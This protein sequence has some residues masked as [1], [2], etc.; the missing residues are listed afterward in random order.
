MCSPS[1][2]RSNGVYSTVTPKLLSL[3]TGWHD[4]IPSK[5]NESFQTS[6]LLIWIETEAGV[7]FDIPATIFVKGTV[8]TSSIHTV[9][10]EGPWMMYSNCQSK[11]VYC[12][13]TQLSFPPSLRPKTGKWSASASWVNSCLQPHS[14]DRQT[15]VFHLDVNSLQQRKCA[16]PHRETDGVQGDGR[17]EGEDCGGLSWSAGPLRCLSRETVAHFWDRTTGARPLSHTP[18]VQPNWNTRPH[19][20]PRVQL[21]RPNSLAIY[22]LNRHPDAFCT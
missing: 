20:K 10:A 15:H 14:K 1:G 12:W 7:A 19:Q 3:Q 17:W 13:G 11:D 8:P 9:E 5:Y 18:E 4:D 21:R 6:F 16:S 2:G 22:S